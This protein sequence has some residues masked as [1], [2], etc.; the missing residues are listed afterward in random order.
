[1]LRLESGRYYGGDCELT[2]VV[3]CL[4]TG[5]TV[6]T[7]QQTGELQLTLFVKNPRACE[8]EARID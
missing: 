3:G 2:M 1:M 4:E 6:T 5:A 7:G 8:T